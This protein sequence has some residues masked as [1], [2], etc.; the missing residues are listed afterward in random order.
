MLLTGKPYE[1]EE[2]GQKFSAQQ[3]LTQHMLIHSNKKPLRCDFPDCGKTFR[4][5]SALSETPFPFPSLTFPSL[6]H[7]HQ[8]PFYHPE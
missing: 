3:A 2:C 7:T 1:C 8:C 5:Q 6:P 4:Q